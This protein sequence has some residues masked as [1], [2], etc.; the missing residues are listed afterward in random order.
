MILMSLLICKRWFCDMCTDQDRAK[1]HVQFIYLFTR[2]WLSHSLW[3]LWKSCE[4]TAHHSIA[5]LVLVTLSMHSESWWTKRNRNKLTKK[6]CESTG[7][8]SQHKG[9]TQISPEMICQII[10]ELI[11][12]SSKLF[13]IIYW[14]FRSFIFYSWSTKPKKKKVRMLLFSFYITVN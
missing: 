4:G 2:P 13:K 3:V 12:K 11:I 1:R 6:K 7:Y 10:N 9:K 8:G 5:R 14:L